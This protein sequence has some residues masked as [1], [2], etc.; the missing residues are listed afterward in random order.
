[1]YNVKNKFETKD[2]PR[3]D[4]PFSIK[5]PQFNRRIHNASSTLISSILNWYERRNRIISFKPNLS[6]ESSACL[7][8]VTENCKHSKVRKKTE[9]YLTFVFLSNC[10]NLNILPHKSNSHEMFCCH[11]NM[12]QD[13]STNIWMLA[14]HVLFSSVSREADQHLSRDSV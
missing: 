5:K 10:H 1:M 4:W 11:N 3:L 14:T 7:T 2:L 13:I 6:R 8:R 9:S 12:D